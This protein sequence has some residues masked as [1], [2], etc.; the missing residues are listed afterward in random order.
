MKLINALLTL[1]ILS[2]QCK[3]EREI[4]QK[5]HLLHSIEIL[6]NS[7]KQNKLN[8]IVDSSLGVTVLYS[9]AIHPIYIKLQHLDENYT[10]LSNTSIPF[11][12][13][14]ELQTL[15]Y[16]TEIHLQQSNEPVVECEN[17]YQYGIFYET[18]N[19]NIITRNI[20][21]LLEVGKDEGYEKDYFDILH[22]DRLFYKSLEKKLIKIT[23][24]YL[25][26]SNNNKSFIVYFSL[27]NKKWYLTVIDFYTL[28]CSV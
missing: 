28:D 10:N 5:N 24:T 4:S 3:K 16:P 19:N 20:D 26:E 1:F 18:E 9:I 2:S 7:D 22:K 21:K 11:W 25:D 17:I 12:I 23:V 13:I 6:L 15:I 27:K 14:D 8:E